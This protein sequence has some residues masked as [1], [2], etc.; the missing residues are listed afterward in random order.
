LGRWLW[1]GLVECRLGRR[2]R[3]GLRRRL[4]AGLECWLGRRCLRLDIV[5]LAVL[6]PV[7]PK[8]PASRR[9]MMRIVRFEDNREAR[10]ALALSVAG[11]MVAMLM[12]TL[13]ILLFY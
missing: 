10:Q 9:L 3:W 1:C 6:T 12:W 13:V 7:R 8:E 11:V 4:A 5:G 2:L